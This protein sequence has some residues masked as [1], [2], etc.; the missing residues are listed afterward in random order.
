[1][2]QSKLPTF[3]LPGYDL[4][5]CKSPDR[6]SLDS[7]FTASSS[8]LASLPKCRTTAARLVGKDGQVMPS[9]QQLPQKLQ[10]CFRNWFLLA[11]ERK[12]KTI[13]LIF[14]TAFFVSWSIFAFLYFLISEWGRPKQCIS[15]VNSFIEAFL[16]SVESQHT[17]GYGY[18][19]ITN[20]CPSAYFLINKHGHRELIGIKDMNVGYDHGWDRVLLLWPVIIRHIIDEQSPLFGVTKETLGSL[21]FE[22]IVTVE[23]NVESTGMTFQRRTSF[24]PDEIK[25]GYRFSP[26][27][28]MNETKQK[29][30]MHYELF[31]MANHILVAKFLPKRTINN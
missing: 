22:I 31:D 15:N 28:T 3:L 2:E 19:Y 11:I 10:I 16:F 17:I 27:I 26:M 6:W 12:W 9:P 13:L 7:G 24:R 5:D 8:T 4:N 20:E 23:G 29:W 25:W 18:R 14:F 1:M 30:E 21:E